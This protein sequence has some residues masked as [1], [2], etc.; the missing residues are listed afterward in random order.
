MCF[1][2]QSDIISTSGGVGRAATLTVTPPT[3]ACTPTTC[4]AQGK[5]CGTISDGCGGTL[6]CG[7][8]TAPQTCGGGG[9]ANVCG[10]GV[11]PPPPPPPPATALLTVTA[12]GRAGESVLSSPAGV[13]VAVGATGSVTFSVGTS[14]TLSATNGRSVIWSGVCNSGGVKTP[15][16]TFTLNA[17]SSETASVP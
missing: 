8:C 7:V 16:C 13:N 14:I 3:A 1:A 17:A 2:A 4:A 6:T 15:S 12:T 11:P 9:V 5:N 10:V